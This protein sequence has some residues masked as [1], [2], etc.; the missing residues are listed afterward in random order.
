MSIREDQPILRFTGARWLN[1]D[2]SAGG[3][4]RMRPRFVASGSALFSQGSQPEEKF[5]PILFLWMMTSSKNEAKFNVFTNLDL[6]LD[7]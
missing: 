1:S 2:W 3:T 6:V 7:I 5:N 4:S